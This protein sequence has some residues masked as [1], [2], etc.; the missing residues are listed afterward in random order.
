M[1]GKTATVLRGYL[2]TTTWY[3]GFAPWEIGWKGR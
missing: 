1:T 3:L 2:V